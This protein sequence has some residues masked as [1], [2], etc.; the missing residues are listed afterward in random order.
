[1]FFSYITAC[2]E[3]CKGC[4]ILQTNRLLYIGSIGSLNVVGYISE[5]FLLKLPASILHAITATLPHIFLG[6]LTNFQSTYFIK[7]VI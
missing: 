5:I 3:V 1:M 4:K 6:N 2:E 7:H